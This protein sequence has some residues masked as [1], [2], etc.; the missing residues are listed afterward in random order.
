L[1]KYY[2]TKKLRL[3]DTEPTQFHLENLRREES[4]V[5][6]YVPPK[7]VVTKYAPNKAERRPVI[8]RRQAGD[9][10]SIVERP[11][12]SKKAFA[13]N[14]RPR[15]RPQGAAPASA[16]APALQKKSLAD[17]TIVGGFR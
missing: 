11:A 12:K 3:T 6:V 13:S 14:D 7:P 8:E 15:P 16:P 17:A 5:C 9:K 1:S 10:K 4:I 2:K